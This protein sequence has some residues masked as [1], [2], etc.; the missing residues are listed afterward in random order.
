[1]KEAITPNASQHPI[2]PTALQTPLMMKSKDGLYI[3]I[4]EAALINYA[5]MSVVL[6]DSNFVLTT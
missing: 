2:G 4:H 3:N 1:M 6:D 5:A